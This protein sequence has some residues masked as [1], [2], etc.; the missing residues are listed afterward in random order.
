M[1]E[2]NF[3]IG[4]KLLLQVGAGSTVEI[5]LARMAGDLRLLYAEPNFLSNAPEGIGRGAW[6][7]GGPSPSPLAS[8]Y[9]PTLL[10]LPAA[11]AI[12]RG[13]GTVVAVLDTGF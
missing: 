5:V 6:A 11:H 12:T 3:H 13:A 8:Q 7:W 4:G 2:S 1:A 10:N 9:A